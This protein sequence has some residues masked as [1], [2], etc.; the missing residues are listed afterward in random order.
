MKTPPQEQYYR[1]DITRYPALT[2]EDELALFVDYHKRRTAVKR[3]KIVRQ[4]LY[5]AAEL[6][7]RYCGP[8]MSK[9]EAISAA[10]YGL[11]QAIEKF[12]PAE[13]KRFVTYSYFAIRREVLYALRDSYVV[14]PESGL[15]ASKYQFSLS[16][17]ES[18]DIA[19]H[20][21]ERREVF[22]NV[23]ATTE[24]GLH[25]TGDDNNLSAEDDF[26]EAIEQGSLLEILAEALPAL[27][28]DL[29]E[30]VDLKYFNNGKPL[31][32]VEIGQR[33]RCTADHVRW[34]HA[35]AMKSLQKL[36]RPLQKEL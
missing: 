30:I 35:R 21:K 5:W 32:F 24:I 36:L 34:L 23:G 11:M 18:N 19:R 8:R 12:D 16:P 33:L 2:T 7:C 17:R 10:N 13:G 9:A 27:P 6:A 26:R 20:K 22:D 25:A 15:W 14:N 28:Q 4:Y 29:R 31:T 1:V 3:E